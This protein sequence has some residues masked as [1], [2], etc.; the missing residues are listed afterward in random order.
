MN[1]IIIPPLSFIE[2]TS[3]KSHEHGKQL[4]AHITQ[5]VFKHNILNKFARYCS[6]VDAHKVFENMI[7]ENNIVLGT[8]IIVGYTQKRVYRR[9]LE[10]IQHSKM[11]MC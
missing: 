6:K 4:C 9:G 7:V 8:T 5:Y 11:C 10:I 3:I 2:C 1:Q